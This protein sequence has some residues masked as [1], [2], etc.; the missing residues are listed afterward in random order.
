MIAI[1]RSFIRNSSKL[2]FTQNV[3]YC[4]N[5]DNDDYRLSDVIL[6]S[7]EVIG[8]D[9][10]EARADLDTHIELLSQYQLQAAEKQNVFLIQPFQ[11]PRYPQNLENY[12]RRDVQLLLEES[13]ALVETLGWTVTKSELVGMA[14]FGKKQ[15]FGSGK[16]AELQ[17]KIALSHS[18]TSG[19][20]LSTYRLTSQQRMNLEN[21]L[22]LPVF[23]RHNIVLQIF[24]RHARTKEAKLQ[25]SLAEI[26]YLKSRLHGDWRVENLMKHSK[27]RKGREFFERREMAL[28]RRESRLKQSLEKLCD[29]RT[30]L[31][32]HRMDMKIP[33]IAVV[34]YTNCGKTSLIKAITE[35]NRLEPRDQ[36]F[37]TLDVTVHET[38]LKPSNLKALF[39]DTVGFISDIPTNLIA[40]FSATLE[41]AVLS[42][43]IVHVRDVSHPDHEAQNRNVLETLA[44]LRIP[45]TLMDNMVTVGN[46]MDKLDPGEWSAL[47]E[48]KLLP[49]SCT[50][51]FGLDVLMSKLDH[52]L[53]ETSGRKFLKIRCRSGSQEEIWLRRNAT[54][55]E[56]IVDPKDSN[57][58]QLSVVMMDYEVEK[59]KKALRYM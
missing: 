21:S 48:L 7:G 59:F 9:N 26:P 10:D 31:R 1:A 18:A 57:Y 55:S 53:L 33:S 4:S 42:D 19:I 44:R 50:E 8:L 52:L 14:S 30:R 20:F 12:V 36:L 38:R 45:Q 5:R 43:L 47:K 17:E 27:Q 11:R 15:F 22:G 13:K 51:G 29:Y 35:S 2:L 56:V 24:Q 3:R 58:L 32:K 41:D 28:K 16:M 54:V 49:I 34:G 25:V 37:A 23:D 40:S 46:K 39:I 6:D